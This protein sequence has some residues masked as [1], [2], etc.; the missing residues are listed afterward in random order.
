M[1]Y[2]KVSKLRKISLA[3][4]P[5]LVLSGCSTATEATPA[6]PKGYAE[7][8]VGISENCETH[9]GGSAAE[10][11]EVLGEF[12][13]Q[14]EVSFPT[15]LSGNGVETKVVIAGDGGPIVGGQRVSL[16]FL[17]FNAQNGEEIQGSEFGTENFISQ[18]LIEGAT[19]DFCKALTGVEVG[20]RVAVLLDAESAHNANGIPSLGIAEDAGVIFI[21][22][23]VNAYLPRAN[24]EAQAP[25]AGMPTVITAPSGQP[26]LQIPNSDAPTEF[27][28]TVLIEGGGEPIELGDTVVLHY[29]GWTWEGDLFDSSWDSGAP[30]S[31]PITYDGLIEGFVMALEGVTVGS[32][33]IAVMPPELGYGDN[34]Q[35]SIPAGS[36]LIFVVDVLGKE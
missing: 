21:F 19:P 17:G 3:L 8:V 11:I 23:V 1:S 10:Q 2:E 35:G 13:S 33:V 6:G 5:L 16:H 36:T 4:L 9:V 14:P 29:S 12:G 25:E 7:L 30:A 28:R 27:R 22:D 31:F 20:S 18:D 34:A 26:G 15:P 24:G 32:Q